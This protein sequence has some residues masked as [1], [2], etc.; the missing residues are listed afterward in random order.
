MNKLIGRM[1][2]Y[3]LDISA[4]RN[5]QQR[6]LTAIEELNVNVAVLSRLESVQ[7]ITGS[8]VRPPFLAV[9]AITR[10]ATPLGILLR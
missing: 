2:P 4:C 3:A 9:A 1:D 8:L 6:L 5:R 7:W 10:R